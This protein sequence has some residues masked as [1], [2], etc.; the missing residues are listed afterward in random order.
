MVSESLVLFPHSHSVAPLLRTQDHLPLGVTGPCKPPSEKDSLLLLF[1]FLCR[2]ILSFQ[3]GINTAA[4]V[5][6][7]QSPHFNFQ[8]GTWWQKQSRQQAREVLGPDTAMCPGAGGWW[9][10]TG[11]EAPGR[12]DRHSSTAWHVGLLTATT[13]PHSACLSHSLL[14][15]LQ[16]CEN[17]GL[18]H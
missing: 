4:Y 6:Y 12:E 5:D 18:D 1:V 16:V 8:F 9:V 11:R 13:Q 10:G 2:L 17:I 7:S 3:W 14:C 15:E